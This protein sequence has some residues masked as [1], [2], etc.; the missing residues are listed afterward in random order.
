MMVQGRITRVALATCVALALAAAA[1]AQPVTSTDLQRL[2]DAVFEASRDVSAVRSTDASLAGR[3]EGQLEEV[4]DDVA[5]LRGK[6]RREGNV[7]R[8]EYDQVW[9]R[10]DDIRSQARGMG[11][12]GSGVPTYG[13][14]RRPANC[15]PVDV[16]VG[17]EIDVRL[18]VPLNSDT[19]NV[20]DRFE[21]TT[22]VSFYNENN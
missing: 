13:P 20:E 22:L 19:A 6:L 8:G 7:G 5:Y 16:C 21:A 9:Q 18:Q 3:L 10:V 14:V 11:S 12:P 15:G 1:Q 2:Q 4:R 17:Q